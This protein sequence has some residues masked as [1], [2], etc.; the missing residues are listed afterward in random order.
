MSDKKDTMIE[1]LKIECSTIDDVLASVENGEGGLEG[2]MSAAVAHH[3]ATCKRCAAKVDSLV[4]HMV[5]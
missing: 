1:L 4:D 5:F 2:L 3:L